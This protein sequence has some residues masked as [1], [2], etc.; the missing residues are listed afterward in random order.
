METLASAFRIN[1]GVPRGVPEYRATRFGVLPEALNG[2]YRRIG[3][4][5]IWREPLTNSTTASSTCVQRQPKFYSNFRRRN[6]NRFW[7]REL[8]GAGTVGRVSCKN[9][10][11][12][13]GMGDR[14]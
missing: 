1:G 14:I 4:A 12:I 5:N 8:R 13:N 2:G 3:G 6:W 7:D 9:S 10:N 11:E